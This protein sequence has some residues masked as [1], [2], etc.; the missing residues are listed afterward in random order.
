[1]TMTTMNSMTCDVSTG[2]ATEFLANYS[3]LLFG[4]GSTCVRLEKN[5][6]RMAQSIGLMAEITILPRHIHLTIRRAGSPEVLTSITSIRDVPINFN[7]I[8]SLSRLSWALADREITFR[9]GIERFG[10]I[11]RMGGTAPGVVL[12]LVSLANASFCRLFEGDLTAMA[13]V[14]VATF[15]GFFLKQ[16]MAIKHVDARI[17]TAVCAFVSA[18]IASA[19]N[20][21]SL[22]ASPMITL[23][24]SVLYLIPGIPLINSFCDMIDRHYICA[25]GRLMNAVVTLC[26]LSFGLCLGMWLMNM[27]M[28]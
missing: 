24:T 26:C 9:E 16:T 10:E 17:I 18:V 21:F 1:M 14:F 2:E 13:I 28:F 6:K 27:G 23:G 11:E 3:G 7:V 5:V 4:S 19:D 25:F 15:A 22:G 20:L 8:T 12:L